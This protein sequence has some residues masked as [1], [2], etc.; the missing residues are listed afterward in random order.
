MNAFKA[1]RGSGLDKA[2]SQSTESQSCVEDAT[3]TSN[4]MAAIPGT[5]DIVHCG[6]EGCFEPSN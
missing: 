1:L 5:E 2:R 6:E 4:L 3:A